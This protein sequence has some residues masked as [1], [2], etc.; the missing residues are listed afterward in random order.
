M[1]TQPV[2]YHSTPLGPSSLRFQVLPYGKRYTLASV[3]HREIEMIWLRDGEVAKTVLP[4]SG[5]RQPARS[6]AE[7]QFSGRSIVFSLETGFKKP[8]RAY[9]HQTS[10]PGLD[11][12]CAKC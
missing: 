12:V 3:D 10:A 11:C 7:S 4:L 1:V 9:N 8:D 6:D 2:I 5:G